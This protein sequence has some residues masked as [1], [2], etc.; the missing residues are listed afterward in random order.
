[1]TEEVVRAS[2]FELVDDDGKLRAGLGVLP[3]G[4]TMLT[5]M[6]DQY[7]DRIA[8]MVTEQGPALVLTSDLDQARV[9]VALEPEGDSNVTRIEVYDETGET[10]FGIRVDGDGSVQLAG[11]AADVNGKANDAHAIGAGL[12]VLGAAVWALLGA[13]DQDSEE[14]DEA[15]RML[16]AASRQRAREF[17]EAALSG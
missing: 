15:T 3:G 17:R 5:L 14:E 10:Q 7:R 6:D 8:L 9:L 4:G 11:W 16:K 12:K 2:R 1:M 13:P